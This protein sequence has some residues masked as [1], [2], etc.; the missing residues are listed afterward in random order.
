ME[1]NEIVDQFPEM[2]KRK[3][4]CKFNDCKHMNEPGCAVKTAVEEGEIAES[5]YNSYIDMVNGID[6]ENPYRTD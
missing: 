5:R 2:F 1:A 6:E 3:N 4:A